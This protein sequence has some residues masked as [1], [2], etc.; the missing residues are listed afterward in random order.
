M[1]DDKPQQ[2]TPERQRHGAFV[3][4]ETVQAGVRVWQAA[5]SREACLIDQLLDRR[6]LTEDQHGAI[7]RYAHMY[8]ISG[9][10]RE[11]GGCGSYG[12]VR[13][14]VASDTAAEAARDVRAMQAWITAGLTS[15]HRVLLDNVVAGDV[16]MP[17]NAPPYWLDGLRRAIGRLESFTPEA[18]RA[19]RLR[20]LGE[21]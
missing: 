13:G 6:Y 20:M 1:R 10:G 7:E 3:E 12:Q 18:A 5:E 11:S 4:T 9:L 2:P 21:Q 14:G 16:I 15:T 19:A 17:D 8:E